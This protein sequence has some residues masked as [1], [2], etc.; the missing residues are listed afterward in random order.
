[1]TPVPKQPEAAVLALKGR[2]VRV[3]HPDKLYFSRQA[4]LTKLDLVRYFLSISPGALAG[5]RDRPLVLKR[6]VDGAEGAAFYQKRAP[7]ARPEWLRTVT[8]AT[9][10]GRTQCARLRVSGKPNRLSRGGGTSRAFGRRLAAESGATP[11]QVRH[12]RCR[13]RRVRQK[14]TLRIVV[15]D[16][17]RPDPEPASFG[18]RSSR[19]PRTPRGSGI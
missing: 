3:T 18:D 16:Q 19:P 4:R 17:H 5:I 13:C 2:E 1:M 15:G 10:S 9:S 14:P 7:S 6:F 8:S 11:V 12:D